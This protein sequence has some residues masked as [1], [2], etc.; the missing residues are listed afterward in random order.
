MS[1]I[2]VP[3]VMSSLNG[4]SLMGCRWKYRKICYVDTVHDFH[5][6]CDFQSS[7]ISLITVI[8]MRSVVSKILLCSWFKCC[9]LHPCWLRNSW[10]SV[11]RRWCQ[12]HRWVPV[13]TEKF[14]VQ[15]LTS[16]TSMTFVVSM[17]SMVI[18]ISRVS[19]TSMISVMSLVFVTTE[20]SLNIGWK[21]DFE[22]YSAT[23]H[24]LGDSPIFLWFKDSVNNRIFYELKKVVK[25][26][27]S[28]SLS[29]L[30]LKYSVIFRIVQ[31]S[32]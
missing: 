11:W 26:L 19:T 29:I 13:L 31:P 7:I 2:S 8:S 32:I 3:S 5:D 15:C 24:N 22:S 14:L 4:I 17:I 20:T 9:S 21:I 12:W 6:V 10:C 30:F 18:M 23:A 28:V 1:M 27:M 25:N 16:A